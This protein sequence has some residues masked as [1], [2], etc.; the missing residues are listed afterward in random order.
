MPEQNIIV[1]QQQQQLE[2]QQSQ[3]RSQVEKSLLQGSQVEKSPSGT[4]I[5][6]ITAG[7]MRNEHGPYIQ[8]QL[9]YLPKFTDEQKESFDKQLEK[10]IKQKLIEKGTTSSVFLIISIKI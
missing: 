10:N 4:A 3:A 5:I 9:S 6:G 2:Q 8:V 1:Q 7:I